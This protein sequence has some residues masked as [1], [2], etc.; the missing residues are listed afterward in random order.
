MVACSRQ[1]YEIIYKAPRFKD[2]GTYFTPPRIT[3]IYN[4]VLVQYNVAIQGPTFFPGIPQYIINEHGDGP[5]QL[6]QHGNPTWQSYHRR[7]VESVWPGKEDKIPNPGRW[8]PVAT[9]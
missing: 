8:E 7:V 5:I 6:Q 9:G 2:S 3:I 4:G 1:T